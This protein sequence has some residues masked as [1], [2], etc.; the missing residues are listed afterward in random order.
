MKKL[1]FHLIGNAHL[2]PVWLWDWREGLN[3]GLITSSPAGRSL[4]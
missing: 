1:M 3:E 4:T 2:D